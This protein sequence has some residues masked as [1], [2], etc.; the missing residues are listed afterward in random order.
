MKKIKL[1]HAIIFFAIFS[2]LLISCGTEEEA[3]GEHLELNLSATTVV[4][5]E[6]ISFELISYLNGDVTTDATFIVNGVAIEGNTFIPEEANDANEVYASFNE[7]IS[8]TKTFKSLEFVPS[9]YTQKVLLEDYTGTWCGYCPRMVT[10]VDYFTA[11]SDRIIPIA[12][13]CQG[14]PS[15]P[16]AYE[17]ASDMIKPENYNA[18]GQP[19]GK[20]N[21]IYDVDQMQGMYPCPNDP[22]VYIEQVLPYLNQSAKL[23]L[24][25]DSSLNG[26]DLKI[27]V[28]VGFAVDELEDA[29]LVVNLIEDGLKHNQIN[30][31]AGGSQNCDPDYDYTSMP[32]PAPNFPQEHVLL[33]SYTDIYGD[34]IPQNEIANGNVWSREFN[35]QLPDNVNNPENLSIVAFVLGEGNQISNRHV[36]NVQ[37]AK[38]GEFQDFD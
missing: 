3:A 7:F 29:R 12:I 6:E 11:Y 28:K 21:R 19:K 38:V 9:E 5:G 34:V 14:S 30:F 8:E 22:S 20:F 37:S 36:I 31:F 26:T 33:K 13:H 4:V 25:I 32:N 23:G 15:D 10:I 2:A 17:F 24:G 18:N 1:T 16:W 35:V 27:N